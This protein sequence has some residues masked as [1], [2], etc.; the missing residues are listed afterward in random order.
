MIVMVGVERVI[1]LS[2]GSGGGVMGVDSRL[3]NIIS[4]V[5]SVSC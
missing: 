1:G 5:N 2:V 3:G 4:M